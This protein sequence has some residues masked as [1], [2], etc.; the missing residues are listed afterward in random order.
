MSP[1]NGTVICSHLPNQTYAVGIVSDEKV[2]GNAAISVW[3]RVGLDGKGFE[4][5]DDHVAIGPLD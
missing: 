4:A 5:K 3:I 2:I 1:V